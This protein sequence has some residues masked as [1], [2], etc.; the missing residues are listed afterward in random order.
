MSRCSCSGR[1]ITSDGQRD[2]DRI[3]GRIEDR[4]EPSPI[5]LIQPADP[6]PA[7]AEETAA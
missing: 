4:K 6:A 7:E 3:A 5:A 1:R 2:L